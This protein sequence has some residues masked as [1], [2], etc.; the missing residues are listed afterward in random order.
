MSVARG[1]RGQQFPRDGP[2]KPRRILGVVTMLLSVY[3]ACQ[4]PVAAAV[5][6]TFI[7]VRDVPTSAVCIRKAEAFYEDV[8]RFRAGCVSGRLRPCVKMSLG[9]ERGSLSP[10]T[11]RGVG[12]HEALKLCETVGLLG[13]Q[14]LKKVYCT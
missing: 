5:I 2:H 8:F 3:S 7:T 9:L 10:D 14:T 11:T 1:R 13:T 4:R 12:P 6:V